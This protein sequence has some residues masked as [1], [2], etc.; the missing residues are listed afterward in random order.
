MA[1]IMI[2]VVENGAVEERELV[3]KKIVKS[4]SVGLAIS[5]MDYQRKTFSKV[6]KKCSSLFPDH[7]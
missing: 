5:G 2:L 7:I 1:I 4:S 6:K 3:V